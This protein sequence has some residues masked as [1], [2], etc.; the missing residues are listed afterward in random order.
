VPG[1]DGDEGTGGGDGRK[2][3]GALGDGHEGTGGGVGE[4]DGGGG[5]RSGRKGVEVVVIAPNQH[6]KLP[7][8]NG[9]WRRHSQGR[10]GVSS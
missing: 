9:N 2:P 10:Q 7:Q 6:A 4:P 1:D 5:G 3:W 8:E